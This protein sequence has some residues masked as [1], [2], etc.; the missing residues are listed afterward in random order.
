MFDEFIKNLNKITS[1]NIKYKDDSLLMKILSYVLFFV[2]FNTFATTIGNNIYLPNREF[3]KSKELDSIA[4]VG[5]EFVHVRDEQRLGSFIYKFLYLFP[6][7][8]VVIFIPLCFINIYLGLIGLFFLLPLPA[9]FRRNLELRGYTG[10]LLGCNIILKRQGVNFEDRVSRLTALVD[11][12][13]VYFTGSFYYFM[14]PFGVRAKL[15][16]NLEKVLLGDIL[17]DQTFAEINLA[18]EDTFEKYD[19]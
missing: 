6:Q 14:W 3:I 11:E 17:N 1:I 7:I 19:I 16:E 2:K 4:L 12:L 5:H 18:M 8:L 10:T 15:K 9:Y 13:N